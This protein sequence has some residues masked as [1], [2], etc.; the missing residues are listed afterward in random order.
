MALSY[1]CDHEHLACLFT[2]STPYH[3]THRTPPHIMLRH[4]V[5]RQPSSQAATPGPDAPDESSSA[6]SSELSESEEEEAEAEGREAEEE[7]D[8]V[9]AAAVDAY[10][11]QRDSWAY[12]REKPS[13]GSLHTTIHLGTR[14]AS[15]GRSYSGMAWLQQC[16]GS[17][18]VAGSVQ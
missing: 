4:A 1:M 12:G 8:P 13:V 5:L 10:T 7:E 17:E 15:I 16:M 9:V 14:A 6:P 11:A 2:P 3:A 18:N